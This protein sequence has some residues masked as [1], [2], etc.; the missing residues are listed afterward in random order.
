MD[1]IVL[2]IIVG[3]LKTAT[4][5]GIHEWLSSD[6]LHT[7]HMHNAAEK[8]S[9]LQA[10]P[11]LTYSPIPMASKS[12]LWIVNVL[13]KAYNGENM[14]L[15][16]HIGHLCNREWTSP[17]F[18]PLNRGDRAGTLL[19]IYSYSFVKTDVH[20]CAHVALVLWISFCGSDLKCQA[21]HVCV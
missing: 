11:N 3:P 6:G 5:F 19:I 2:I 7:K 8:M 20:A 18:S 21:T 15:H 17:N 10:S 4:Q 12:A 1:L 9:R 16:Q 14:Y 13:D